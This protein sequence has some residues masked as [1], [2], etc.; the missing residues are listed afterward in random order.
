M[1]PPSTTSGPLDLFLP[2]WAALD[3]V[4]RHPLPFALWEIGDQSLLCH[5]FDH[6]VNAGHAS[7]RIHVIDRPADI[8]R[9]VKEATLWPLPLEV[10]TLGSGATPPAQAVVVDTL[11]G[12]RAERRTP[13]D[14][15]ELL[16]LAAALE[17][18]W[19][20]Q[21][22]AD[23]AGDLLCIGRSCRIHP[24][25]ILYPPYFIGDDV[26]IGPGCEIGPHAAIGS[27][28]MLSGANVVVRSQIAAHS[29]LGP[30]TALDDCHLDGNLLLNRRNRARLDL[31]EQ[32]LGASLRPADRRNQPGWSERRL[33]R[34]LARRFD[35]EVRPTGT[36]HLHNGRT[37]P[38]RG[39]A[40]FSTRI[41]W[42]DE[43][44][45]GNMRLFGVLP[46]TREQ[47]DRLPLEWR[48]A[49]EHAP[50]GVF[51]YADCHGCHSP[52]HPDEALHAV[53]QATLDDEVLAPILRN[54][55]ETLQPVGF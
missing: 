47:L 12:S 6:A 31:V 51:S 37:L 25:A 54:F 46:R 20:D 32:H 27:G 24:D 8:R 53:Y 42:L 7:V 5:W 49:L 13:A 34:K 26:F 28:S 23:P 44:S 35:G 3:T 16:D 21:L 30:M 22:R 11:P 48:S 36:F 43:V 41:Q 40:D 14:G 55:L 38:G 17:K 19:L 50:V 10:V 45:S 52:D 29:F 1:T 18:E 33:A 4:R 39:P 15:W 9:A 2:D